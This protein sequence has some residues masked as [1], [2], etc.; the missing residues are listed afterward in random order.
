[1]NNNLMYIQEEK[2]NHKNYLS[3]L[4]QVIKIQGLNYFIRF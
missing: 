1:M 4:C 3:S 2:I